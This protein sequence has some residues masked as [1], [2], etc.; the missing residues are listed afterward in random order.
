MG[1]SL[2]RRAARLAKKEGGINA[3][4]RSK[5]TS[6]ERLFIRRVAAAYE[7]RRQTEAGPLLSPGDGGRASMVLLCGLSKQRKRNWR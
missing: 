2:I 4:L 6:P 5:F 1:V 3:V 7:R